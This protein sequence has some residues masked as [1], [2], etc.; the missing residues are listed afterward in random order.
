MATGIRNLIR[1]VQNE[2]QVIKIKIKRQKNNLIL[3]EMYI[4]VINADRNVPS[5]IIYI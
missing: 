3:W 2:S 5:Y 1:K 4:R